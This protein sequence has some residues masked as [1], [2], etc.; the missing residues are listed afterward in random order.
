MRRSSRFNR[1]GLTGSSRSA[2]LL[3]NDGD[4]STLTLDFTTGSLDPRLSFSRLG[5]A[6]FIN[7]SGLVQHA[8]ANKF[9]NSVF[10]GAGGTTAP[11]GW[12]FASIGGTGNLSLNGVELTISNNNSAT[13]S[14]LY[15]NWGNGNGL[16]VTVQ[17]RVTAKSGTFQ[18]NEVL[19]FS[20]NGSTADQ[21]AVNGVNQSSGYTGWG[22][23]DLITLT[24]IPTNGAAAWCVVGCGVSSAQATNLSVTIK[25]IQAEPGTVAR[26]YIATTT[27]GAYYAPRFDYDPTTLAPRGLLIEGQ[28]VNSVT[29]SDTLPTGGSWTA[30]SVTRTNVSALTPDGNTTTTTCGLSHT[31]S[32]SFRSAAITVTANTAYTF[33]FWA[34][35]NG[36]SVALYRAYNVSGSA[37]IVSET[38]YFSQI[39]GATWTR[40]QFTFTTP[41]GCTS[42][43]VY[44]LSQSS[45]TSNILVWGAMLEQG[46]GA[47]S[48]IP[49]GASTATRAADSCVMSDISALNYSTQFGSIYWSGIINKQPTSYITLIGFMTAGDQPTYETFGNAL[50]YFTAARGAS[51]SAGGAN[52]VSRP[53]TLGSLIKYASAINT[54]TDPIV[55]VNLN[56]SASSANKTGTGDLYAATRFVIGRQPSS[57]YGLNYPSGTIALVKYWPTAKTASELNALTT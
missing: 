22:A 46:S 44:P 42:V 57:T 55:R 10:A 39:N 34:K 17:F 47:S 35:N 4:G 33:S 51:L 11:T 15:Q 5:D 38:S 50:N 21:Y 7:S 8:A 14:R 27:S 19:A 49:T 6:T 53:Y 32:G 25:D 12:T 26:P 13:R 23:G 36:G 52:E 28:A 16:P 41:A 29:N 2:L 45:G 24:C 37:D 54:V 1:P 20:I 30:N 48:Y 40:I 9:S 3:N 31:G 43:Y 56:G 18:L